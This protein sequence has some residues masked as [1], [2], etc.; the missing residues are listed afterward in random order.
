MYFEKEVT[1]LHTERL[2][3]SL[4]LTFQFSVLLVSLEIK[5]GTNV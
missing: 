2:F 3:V 1:L 4:Y 5:S